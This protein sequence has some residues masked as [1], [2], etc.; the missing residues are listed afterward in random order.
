[1]TREIARSIPDDPDD[2]D[3]L[4]AMLLCVIDERDAAQCKRDAAQHER[5]APQ[6]ERDA[7]LRSASATPPLPRPPSRTASSASIS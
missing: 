5:D 7:P 3:E 2:P 4:R 1:V 6:Y